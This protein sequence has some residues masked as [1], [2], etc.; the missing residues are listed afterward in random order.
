L[1]SFEV[2]GRLHQV[3]HT[4]IVS[5]GIVLAAACEEAHIEDG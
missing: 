3:H 2:R 1:A 5:L 4:L